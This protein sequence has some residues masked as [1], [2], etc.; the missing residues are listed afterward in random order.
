MLAAGL[1][2]LV[3]SLSSA[4]AKPVATAVRI[5]EHVDMTR[6]V[7][8]LSESVEHSI[9]VLPDPYRVVIDL[10]ETEWRVS[11]ASANAAAGL[12]QRYRFGLYQAGISRLVLD[13]AGPVRVHRAFVLPPQ[14]DFAYRFVID[15]KRTDRNSFLQQ[16]GSPVGRLAAV[17]PTRPLPQVPPRRPDRPVVVL[18]PGH[19][20]VDPGTIGAGGTYEKTV[21]LRVAKD[22]RQRLE[23]TGRY[24]VVM[25]RNRDVFVRLHDRVKIARQAGADLFLSIHA[26]AIN[27][28]KVRGATVY[29][30]SET[31]SDAEA[32][33]LAAKENK[34]DVIAGVD[35]AIHNDDV[36]NILID[37]AQRDTM[38]RSA[39]FATILVP[40]LKRTV[41]VRAK[42]HRSA[43][44]RVLKAPDVPSV[45]IEL[46]YLS[47]REDEKLLNS[48]AGRTAM[49]KAITAA[50]SRY[51]EVIDA[52]NR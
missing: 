52:R 38:N 47:N 40:S 36:A 33:A 6:F 24:Q 48:Q 9:F 43:G 35:L 46:G 8:D 34:A 45:L 7:I 23:A 2:W 50:V 30:L 31:A 39:Q 5:G 12:V 44:F 51:F 19:G 15:L 28:R 16:A 37:L 26:D 21:V 18:D 42:P 11:P 13:A 49:A 1:V 41:R 4:V 22:I 29:T 10:P 20:G 27:Q 32:E 14:G 17:R 25:T 3:L